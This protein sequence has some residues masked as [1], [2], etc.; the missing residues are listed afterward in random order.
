MVQVAPPPAEGQDF[1]NVIVGSFGLTG[2]IVLGAVLSGSVLAGLWILWRKWRR[3]YDADAPPTLG[4]V[5]L[6]SSS[7]TT[8]P[9]SSP[10]Q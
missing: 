4:P 1:K 6:S 10:D 8:R 2:A 7:T 5:P 9:P 3:T